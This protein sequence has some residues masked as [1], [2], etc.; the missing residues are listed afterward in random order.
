MQL[1]KSAEFVWTDSFH[2][3]VFCLLFHRNFVVTPSY[4]GGEGRILSLLKKIGLERFFY[5]CED[6][7]NSKIWEEKIDYIK[8]EEKLQTLR[9]ESRI[10]LL[11]NL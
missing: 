2:C 8:V 9:K 1:I 3:M 10:Y 5:H 11:K 4:K 6:V 7:V